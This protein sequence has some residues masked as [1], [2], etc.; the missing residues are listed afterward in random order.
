MDNPIILAQDTLMSE[1][2]PQGRI[3]FANDNFCRVS[4]YGL[5]E[6]MGQPHNIV[7]HPDMPKK[8]FQHLW[9]VIRKGEVFRGVIKNKAKDGTHYWVNTTI[10]PIYKGPKIVKHLSG[11]YHIK[12][13]QMAQQL[14]AQQVRSLGLA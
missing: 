12:D 5:D 2:D 9:D 11:R 4:Q 3:I 13:E 7:R 6:L 14:Y 8:L 1:T 10:I